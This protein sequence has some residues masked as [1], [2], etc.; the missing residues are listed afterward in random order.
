MYF[1][2]QFL[3][4]AGT[5]TTQSAFK[6]FLTE[7]DKFLVSRLSPLAD[8]GGYAVASNYGAYILPLYWLCSAKYVAGSLVARIIFQPIEETAR[9]FFSKTLSSES[10]A[11][12]EGTDNL[13]TASNVLSSL[14]LMFSHLL[15]LLV[16][17][18]PPY[19]PLALSLVLPARYL[20]T[21]AP[22]ILHTY[23]YYIPTMA[24]N[25]VLEAFFASAASSSDLRTQS[26]WMLV[27]SGIFVAAAV[28][29]SKGL[30]LGDSGLVWANV[31]NLCLRALYAWSFVRGYFAEKG[32]KDLMSVWRCVPPAGVLFA[33][34]LSAVVTRA[35]GASYQNAP[36]TIVGQFGHIVIGVACVL[37]CVLTW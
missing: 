34:G 8:Q 14:L 28:T 16:T 37:A 33:F 11:K 10:S 2:S 4:L 1:E 18:A 22:S 26:W 36:L 32:E 13:K 19:L 12:K 7:G 35:T 17:F 29:L 9:L 31:L 23:V 27:F 3:S 30:S 15:L 6:H 5:M 24:F 25:G 20:N 21:S